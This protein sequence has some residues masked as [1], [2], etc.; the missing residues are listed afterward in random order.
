VYDGSHGTDEARGTLSV[1]YVYGIDK[2]WGA[3]YLFVMV[4]M[5]FCVSVY[6][7]VIDK[8]FCVSIPD[9]CSLCVYT[10][11]LSVSTPDALSLSLC[12]PALSGY[13]MVGA[14]G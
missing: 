9:A 11:S 8:R 7:Y 2:E 1:V 12:L 14:M 6:V 13:L 10:C 3:L 4:D 5:R